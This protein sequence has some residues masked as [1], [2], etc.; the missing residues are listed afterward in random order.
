MLRRHRVQRIIKFAS[1][2]CLGSMFLASSVFA[3]E[4]P[5]MIQGVVRD[6]ETNEFLDYANILIKGTTRGT[7]SLGG[8]AFYFPGLRPGTYTIQV[9]YLGYAPEETT[10]TLRSGETVELSFDMKVVIVETLGAFD[11]EGAAYMVEVKSAT[12]E[13]KIDAERFQKYAID[14]VDDAL[15]KQAG[16]VMRAGELYV[17]GGRSG[18]V[19]MRIDDVPVDNPLGGQALEV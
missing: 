2:C 1:L 7:M 16:I 18:E 3:Q 8:G 17:R 12:S 15:S 5:G 19:S 13:Q 10:V 14:S 4:L 6:D 9:L 11:V